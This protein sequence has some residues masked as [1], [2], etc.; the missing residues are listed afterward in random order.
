MSNGIRDLEWEGNGHKPEEICENAWGQALLEPGKQKPGRYISS[1]CPWLLVGVT[2]SRQ[3]AVSIEAGGARLSRVFRDFFLGWP[4][5]EM[6]L[7][8][9]WLGVRNLA[10]SVGGGGC[11]V[12]C[13]SIQHAPCVGSHFQCGA[14]PSL[15]LACQFRHLQ[16][17]PFRRKIPLLSRVPGATNSSTIWQ[18]WGINRILFFTCPTAQDWAFLILLH[19]FPFV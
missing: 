18:F 8:V 13:L 15:C 4:L 19:C 11:G 6:A 10:A 14:L 9:S 17:Y 16:F 12:A 7:S 3:F 1:S 2:G 5:L